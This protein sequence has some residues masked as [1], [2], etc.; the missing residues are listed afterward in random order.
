M[1]LLTTLAL[2]AAVVSGAAQA[3]QKTLKVY[4]WF[5]YITPKALDDFKAQNPQIKLVYDNFDTNEALE[6]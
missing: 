1:K 3:E 4:N 6:A 2:C 5:D